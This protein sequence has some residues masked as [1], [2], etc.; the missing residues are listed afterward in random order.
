MEAIDATLKKL[1]ETAE[2]HINESVIKELRI[3]GKKS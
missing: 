2:I 3:V 1:R